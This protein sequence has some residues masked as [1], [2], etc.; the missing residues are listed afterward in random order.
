MP[1]RLG[2]IVATN[3]RRLRNQKGWSQ[4][5]LADFA[6]VDKNTP[7]NIEREE[8]SPTVD[9]V[10]RLALTLGVA[11]I[12]MFQDNAGQDAALAAPDEE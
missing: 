11:P 5:E 2:E 8:T 4:D 12:V 3:L 9:M 6:G 10:E 7:G 1:R